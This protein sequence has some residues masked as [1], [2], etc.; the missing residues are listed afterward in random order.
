MDV[1]LEKE[2]EQVSDALQQHG[3]RLYSSC[4]GVI[5]CCRFRVEFAY[6]HAI[7]FDA[8]CILRLQ[9]WLRLTHHTQGRATLHGCASY[10]D[11]EGAQNL[12]Q[13]GADVNH[14]SR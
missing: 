13:Q 14:V 5:I 8:L 7:V 11:V 6:S 12:L 4:L 2:H 3:V 10:N 9:F 1:A